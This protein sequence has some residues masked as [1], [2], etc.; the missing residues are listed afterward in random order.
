MVL[1]L[2]IEAHIMIAILNFDFQKLNLIKIFKLKR[3]RYLVFCLRKRHNLKFNFEKLIRKVKFRF[4]Y[5]IS[6]IYL[7]L[8]GMMS[9]QHLSWLRGLF[10]VFISCIFLFAQYF[11]QNKVRYEDFHFKIFKTEHFD[12]YY[13]PEEENLITDA[14]KM[15]ERW[16]ARHVRMFDHRLSGRQAIIFYSCP[17]QFEQTNII[18]GQIGEGTGGVTEALKRRVVLPFAGPLKE[19]DHVIGHELV[20][21]FQYDITGQ[22]KGAMH[23]LPAALQLPLWFIEGMAEYFSLGAEDAN[24]TMWLRD[25]VQH[26]LPSIKDLENPEYFPY[27]FGQ[28]F[29]AYI[30]GKWGDEKISMILKL[31]RN[32]KSV[33]Q[34]MEEILGV[35]VD[36]L[37]KDWHRVLH[38]T[39]DP[40][41]QECTDPAQNGPLIIKANEKNG[42]INVAPA[43]SPD[44]KYLVY[45]S[46]KDVFTINLFLADAKTGKII[47]KIVDATRNPHLESLQF[48]SSSGSWNQDGKHF[49]FAAVE[50]G[51][52]VLMILNTTSGKIERS[53]RF[54]ELGQ[55]L[56]PS[57]APDGQ[58]I[59]FSAINHGQSDLFIFNLQNDSLQQITNDAYADLQPAWGP[60]GRFIAF[61]TDRFSTD[62]THYDFGNYQLALYDLASQKI[63]L[64]PCFKNGKNINPQ[65]SAQ[66]E[67]LYFVSDQSG[68]SNIYRLNLS[69]GQI[70]QLTNVFTGVSGITALSPAI[71][72][73]SH[74]DKLVYTVFENR[75]Y[76][77]YAIE[78]REKLA[79]Q[80]AKTALNPIQLTILPPVNRA[81]AGV[82]ALKSNPFFG[83]PQELNANIVPYKPKLML[84]YIGQPY[85]AVGASRFGTYLAGGVSLYWSDM[86]ND[87][88]LATAIQA[89]GSLSDI[90][91][92]VS[93]LNQKK[94]WNWGIAVQRIPYVT[95]AFSSGYFKLDTT[96]VYVEDELRLAQYTNSLSGIWEYPFSRAQRLE[97]SGSYER[98][99]FKKQENITVYS[100]TG[101]ELFDR[102]EHLPAPASL[103]L[104]SLS[105][106]LVYDQT[107]F[108]MTSPLLGKRYRFEVAPSF[109]SLQYYTF[110]ADYR[111]YEMP[112]KPFTVAM[113]L[114][115]YARYGK[116]AEDSRLSPLY[117]G[118]QSF[119]RGYEYNSFTPEEVARDPQKGP[120]QLYGS[121]IVV[122]NLELRFPL[123]GL[124]G[125]GKGY[126]GILPIESALFLDS[127]LSWT[128]QEKPWFKNGNRKLVRSI[129]LALRF[130]LGY[131]MGELD[132]VKP[133]D[134]P[135]NKWRFQFGFISGF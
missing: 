71:S 90:G 11:G 64:L 103:D 101:E 72:S 36:S 110:L 53:I 62:L 121:K 44:G 55:I 115:H 40:L 50:K 75:S 63:W 46:E 131:F 134:R 18:E 12:L 108:G 86:L 19:T 96:I 76:S 20:H 37:S 65:W 84:D 100:L 61:V 124:L 94:R 83:L 15:A 78:S 1:F 23:H 45:F 129:G 42:R 43:L 51:R 34:A 57:W 67:S 21:A 74:E 56:N 99:S 114:L 81:F 122:G 41:K 135:D 8:G 35:S 17:P 31:T 111:R 58:H 24:S 27:R 9:A 73:A 123:F 106:A 52:P 133:F 119:I 79:G 102:T 13:Y 10:I 120:A 39:Y 98:I 38:E 6:I 68:I 5:S 14:A 88:K 87:H 112:L 26:K 126:Y 85:L 32:Q 25:A 70:F 28:A 107:F 117:L 4:R 54:S 47:R 130:N 92:M 82:R 49:I 2:R 91:G 48:I 125:L 95:G 97:L 7:Y 80:L 33:Y 118:Y 69:T 132:Y 89:N 77:I 116:N 66:G 104:G 30:G 128:K 22:G 59:V 113:R 127:G 16:Y 109:G 29:L 3:K 93:Y 105:L 60:D